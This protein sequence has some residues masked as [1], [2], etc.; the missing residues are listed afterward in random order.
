LIARIACG[1]PMGGETI[2]QA[3]RPLAGQGFYFSAFA[4][5]LATPQTKKPWLLAKA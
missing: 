3:F 1:D 2:N 4:S 5:K